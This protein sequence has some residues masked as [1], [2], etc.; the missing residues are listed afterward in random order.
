VL[1]DLWQVRDVLEQHSELAAGVHEVAEAVSGDARD[2][3]SLLLAATAAARP[4]AVVLFA[5]RRVDRIAAAVRAVE[6]GLPA[7]TAPVVQR[8]TAAVTRRYASTS[9][10]QAIDR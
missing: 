4:E 7:G 2:V 8:L 10:R 6:T 5:S 3:G 1:G 9:S